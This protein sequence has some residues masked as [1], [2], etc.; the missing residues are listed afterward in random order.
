MNSIAFD[1][2]NEKRFSSRIQKFFRR[3]QV[4]SILKK[5]NAYSPTTII[6]P[7]SRRSHTKANLPTHYPLESVAE[8]A[9]PSVVLPE[10]IRVIDKGRLDRRIGMLSEKS[11][12]EID[13]FSK[14]YNLPH[15]HPHAFRHT[16][17]STTASIYVHHIKTVS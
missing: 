15:I 12:W 4:S 6:A 1:V 14:K 8:L 11:M 10:Q 16:P 2:E 9:Q 3:Y 17:A 13:K 7:I 5:C